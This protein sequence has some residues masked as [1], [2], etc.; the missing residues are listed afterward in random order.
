MGIHQIKMKFAA[1]LFA[2]AQANLVEELA[3]GS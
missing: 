3:S 1:T 2:L